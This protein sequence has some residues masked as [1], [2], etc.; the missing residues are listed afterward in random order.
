[1]QDVVWGTALHKQQP[2]YTRLSSLAFNFNNEHAACNTN[3][4][5]FP[6]LIFPQNGNDLMKAVLKE[7]LLAHPL[8]QFLS[9]GDRPSFLPFSNTVRVIQYQY[10]LI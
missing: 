10:L 2:I 1:M 7:I 4:Q 8:K 3:L 6:F 9:W 5:S